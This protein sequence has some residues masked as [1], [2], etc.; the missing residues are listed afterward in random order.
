M[1]FLLATSTLGHVAERIGVIVV[2]LLAATAVLLAGRPA[3]VRLRAAA[4]LAAL[5]LTP[6]L[7]I[8]DIWHS[9]Q[10]HPLRHHPL[11]GVAALIGGVRLRA[12]PPP[13]VEPPPAPL[14][15]A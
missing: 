1:S 6:V 13:P 3:L 15:V 10:L 11:Y 4:I 2:A 14:A 12:P 5:V 8:A 7:L 9:P